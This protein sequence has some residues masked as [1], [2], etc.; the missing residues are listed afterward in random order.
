[1]FKH[2][3]T[4]DVAYNS[5]LVQR[6]KVLHRIIGLAIEE[7][8]ADRLAE[9]YEMLAHH[10]ARAEEWPKALAYLRQAAAKAAGR[11]AHREAVAHLEEALAVL[12]NLPEGRERTEAAVDVRCDLRDSLVPL[13]EYGRIHEFLVE[14]EPLAQRLGDARR[15]ARIAAYM[16]DFLFATVDHERAVESGRRTLA[17]ANDLED[18]GL[19][20]AANLM[21]AW[22][23]HELADYQQAMALLTW[24]VTALSGERRVQRFGFPVLPSVESHGLLAWCLGWQ[25]Q[26]AEGRALVEDAAD[27]A[28]EAGHPQTLARAAA[29]AGLL[30]AMRGDVQAAVAAL[31]ETIARYRALHAPAPWALAFL[32]WAYGLGGRMT[33]ALPLFEESLALAA[34]MK[35]LPCNSI[36]IIWWGETCL[37]A[38]RLDEAAQHGR[39]ALKITRTQKERGY[40][41]H[42]LRLLGEVAAGRETL[43]VEAAETLYREAMGLAEAVDLRPLVAR[44]HLGLG[45]LWLRSGDRAHADAHLATALAA[46]RAMDMPLW[47]DEAERALGEGRPV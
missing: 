9:H 6:R 34:A 28:R 35:F 11:S 1:M 38:G 19:R 2:E 8:Y 4:R 40:E 30:H 42:A 33:E 7:L 3:L 13:V 32:A 12:R 41:A 45:R 18:L 44:C 15:Q 29:S 43:E 26:F 16:T 5:L 27:I 36:W 22:P 10:F 21:T 14:A 24:N 25:G 17:I 31:E 37:A 23:Y 46:F 39:Q 20:V 47:R